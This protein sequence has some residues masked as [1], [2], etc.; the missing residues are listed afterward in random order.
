VQTTGLTFSHGSLG[1][2][3]EQLVFFDTEDVMNGRGIRPDLLHLL[4]VA[5]ATGGGTCQ[6]APD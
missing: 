1:N 3:L 4:D 6:E 2:T 5:R